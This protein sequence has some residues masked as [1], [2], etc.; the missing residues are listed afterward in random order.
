MKKSVEK[1]IEDTGAKNNEKIDWK[2]DWKIMAFRKK[3]DSFFHDL[4]ECIKSKT[5]L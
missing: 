2:I 1:S 5:I 3:I 4:A